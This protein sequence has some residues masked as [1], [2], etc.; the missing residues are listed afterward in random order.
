MSGTYFDH[1]LALGIPWR[2]PE[3]ILP[4]ILQDQPDGIRFLITE[5]SPTRTSSQ[6]RARLSV[7]TKS[8]FGATAENSLESV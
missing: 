8:P 5:R 1:R 2:P 3:S 4:T 7:R 6:E